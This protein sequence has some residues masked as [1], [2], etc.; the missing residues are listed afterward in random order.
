[1]FPVAARILTIAVFIG[2]IVV[3]LFNWFYPTVAIND[4]LTVITLVSIL[5]AFIADYIWKTIQK[6]SKN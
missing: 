2:A 6:K 1:M 3:A 4:V 5:L